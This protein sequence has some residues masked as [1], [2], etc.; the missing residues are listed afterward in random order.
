M[1]LG[2]R[3]L[4]DLGQQVG[5]LQVALATPEALEALP[6]L[7]QALQRVEDLG[8]LL[9]ST[10]RALRENQPG[11]DGG[12][13]QVRPLWLAQQALVPLAHAAERATWIT[14][15]LAYLSAFDLTDAERAAPEEEVIGLQYELGD[16][17]ATAVAN[18]RSGARELASRPA[19]GAPSR[20]A[21]AAGRAHG[22][23][24]PASTARR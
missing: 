10:A 21:T 14:S 11:E 17:L 20:V 23:S 3:E 6:T 9:A 16:E 4:I 19:A 7:E 1:P 12:P 2:S 24:G 22:Q 8:A 18:L 15:N 13:A 5:P